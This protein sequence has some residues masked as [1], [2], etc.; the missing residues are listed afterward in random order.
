MKIGS[1]GACRLCVHAINYEVGK[2]MRFFSELLQTRYIA[3]DSTY[4]WL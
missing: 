1:V 4:I 2:L 3:T